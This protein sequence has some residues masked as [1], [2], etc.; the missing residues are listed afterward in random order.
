MLTSPPHKCF[1]QSSF[2]FRQHTFLST[3]WCLMLL[4][5]PAA[6]PLSLQESFK[7]HFIVPA[8]PQ[9]RSPYTI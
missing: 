7:F 3:A 5:T 1:L 9:P 6:N 8:Q 2:R 4:F